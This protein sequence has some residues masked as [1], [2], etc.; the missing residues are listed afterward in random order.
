MEWSVIVL[1]EYLDSV[2]FLRFNKTIIRKFQ[3]FTVYMLKCWKFYVCQRGCSTQSVA[4]ETGGTGV[5]V[6]VPPE[7]TVHMVNAQAYGDWQLITSKIVIIVTQLF[8]LWH[9]L[10]WRFVK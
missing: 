2:V 5:Q 1:F 6:R 10:R 8:I 3:F 7:P 4:P 9:I